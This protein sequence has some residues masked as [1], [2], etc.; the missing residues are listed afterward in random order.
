MKSRTKM[1][2][3]GRLVLLVADWSV[4]LDSTSS[5]PG[6]NI[7]LYSNDIQH[8]QYCLSGINR[9]SRISQVSCCQ[10]PSRKVWPLGGHFVDTREMSK[11]DQSL[12]KMKNH[13]R[14]KYTEDSTTHAW[15]FTNGGCI[16]TSECLSVIFRAVGSLAQTKLEWRSKVVTPSLH[17]PGCNLGQVT[18]P[19]PHLGLQVALQG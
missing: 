16:N 19:S 8:I 4:S 12:S 2:P 13:Y 14:S 6:W 5:F 10:S 11:E 3:I 17:K 15:G 18:P 9:M 7:F 1:E